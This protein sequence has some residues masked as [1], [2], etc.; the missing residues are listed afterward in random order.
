MPP[1]NVHSESAAWT[2]GPPAG[3]GVVE[4]LAAGAKPFKLPVT[5]LEFLR[6]TNGAEGSVGHPTF[7]WCQLWPAEQVLARNRGY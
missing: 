3:P 5:Y 4:T 1:G 6:R 7:G 2:P